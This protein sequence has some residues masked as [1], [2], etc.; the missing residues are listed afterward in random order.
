M[1]PQKDLMSDYFNLVESA[2]N[3]NANHFKIDQ[4]TSAQ[5][6]QILISARS[7]LM[8]RD[9]VLNSTPGSFADRFVNGN[10]FGVLDVADAVTL[11]SL[12]F[13]AYCYK[14]KYLD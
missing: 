4:V 6:D 1:T 5:R 8:I 14:Q 11:K 7:I 2:Y 3:D 12:T 13:F 9:G 10:L